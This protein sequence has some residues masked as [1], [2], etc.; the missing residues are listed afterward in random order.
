MGKML[1]MT[2]AAVGGGPYGDYL[3]CF[4][5]DCRGRL[6]WRPANKI[7]G[8]AATF[9]GGGSGIR[10]AGRP[11]VRPVRVVV[12]LG[13]SEK[14]IGKLLRMTAGRLERRPL[15]GWTMDFS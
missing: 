3:S 14:F 5:S 12:A 1:H 2:W 10:L 4:V 11:G 13:E 6:S 8:G 9:W 7:R 15:Q